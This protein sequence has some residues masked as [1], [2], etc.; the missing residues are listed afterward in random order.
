VPARSLGSGARPAELRRPE[1]RGAWACTGPSSS[2]AAGELAARTGSGSQQVASSALASIA[3]SPAQPLP[4]PLHVPLASSLEHHHGTLEVENHPSQSP[5]R[6]GGERA[7]RHRASTPRESEDPCATPR[8]AAAAHARTRG[9]A[10]AL[11]TS[12]FG[13]RATGKKKRDKIDC[14][15][16]VVL[17]PTIDCYFDHAGKRVRGGPAQEKCP[18]R[19]GRQTGSISDLF[20]F[21]L[22]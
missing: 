21:A 12:W 3:R 8:G 15:V 5:R 11:R 10:S 4:P 16:I 2:S 1:P 13:G 19:I 22:H 17:S 20:M 18:T 9:E 7:R 6:G 14:V